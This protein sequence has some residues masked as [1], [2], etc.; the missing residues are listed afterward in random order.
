[1]AEMK[2]NHQ[3]IQLSQNQVPISFQFSM[4]TIISFCSVWATNG[5]RAKNQELTA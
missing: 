2:N 4:K 1:M 5:T 3:A